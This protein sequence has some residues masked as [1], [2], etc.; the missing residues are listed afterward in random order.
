MLRKMPVRFRNENC[1]DQIQD[2]F[3]EGEN[4]YADRY[5]VFFTS[6]EEYAGMDYIGYRCMCSNPCHPLGIGTFN[7]MK[8]HEYS[9]Y[10]D[11]KRAKR[12]KWSDLPDNVKSLLIED[13]KD[14]E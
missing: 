10:R 11:R 12:I 7:Q 8:T 13:C 6:I 2:I 5:T 4:S 1:P 9:S 3:D 14:F